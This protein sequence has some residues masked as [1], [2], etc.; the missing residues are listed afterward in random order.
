MPHVP[1]TILYVTSS[2]PTIPIAVTPQ[3]HPM[4]APALAVC[5]SGQQAIDDLFVGFVGSVIQERFDLFRRWGKTDQIEI[6]ASQ[7]GRFVCFRH[8]LKAPLLVLGGYEKINWTAEPGLI[9]DLGQRRPLRGLVRPMITAMQE[10]FLFMRN[11]Q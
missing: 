3:V 10:C 1:L 4:S 9:L 6:D 7:Q 2:S 8:R 5:G 11:F